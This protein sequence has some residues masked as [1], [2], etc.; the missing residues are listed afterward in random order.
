MAKGNGAP[1]RTTRWP[2]PAIARIDRDILKVQQIEV[3]DHFDQVHLKVGNRELKMTYETALK[4]A[5]ML[6][7]HGRRAKAFAGDQRRH[8]QVAGLLSDAAQD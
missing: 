8:L 2:T 4:I 6:R 3:H 5:Q 7:L 1:A